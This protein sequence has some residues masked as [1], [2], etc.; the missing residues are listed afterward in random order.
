MVAEEATKE[1][2]NFHWNSSRTWRRRTS[3][4][5][6]KMNDAFL[7]SWFG[8]GVSSLGALMGS[9][10]N[11]KPSRWLPFR[12]VFLELPGV[13]GSDPNQKCLVTQNP[14]WSWP[15]NMESPSDPLK[16]VGH[17]PKSWLVMDP[18][19][20]AMT[21]HYFGYTDQP[22]LIRVRSG[23]RW[24]VPRPPGLWGGANDTCLKAANGVGRIF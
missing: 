8:F 7:F 20:K 15:L 6:R 23:D 16:M 5:R 10:G 14:G 3:S 21:N 2:S 19:L 13:S 1:A 22:F 9:R 11:A 24:G 17:Y 12:P 18:C 4:C